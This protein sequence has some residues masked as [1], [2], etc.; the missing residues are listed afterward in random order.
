IKPYKLTALRNIYQTSSPSGFPQSTSG[1]GG[2]ITCDK[3]S[4][5]EGRGQ[6]FTG[7]EGVFTPT[8]LYFFLKEEV[9][10]QRDKLEVDLPS[11]FCPYAKRYPLGLPSALRAKPDKTQ[12]NQKAPYL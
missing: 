7:L 2:S 3:S 12:A 10:N 9:L 5:N 1:S 8:Q 6:K 11:A 4:S